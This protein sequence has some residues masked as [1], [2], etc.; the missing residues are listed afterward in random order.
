[1]K[2]TWGGG[3]LKGPQFLNLFIS[4]L[5]GRIV[6]FTPRPEL[7]ASS[8][9]G[10]ANQSKNWGGKW[11]PVRLLPPFNNLRRVQRWRISTE[12]A[13]ERRFC[14]GCY[15]GNLYHISRFIASKRSFSSQKKKQKKNT[16]TAARCSDDAKTYIICLTLIFKLVFLVPVIEANIYILMSSLYI[17]SFKHV[18]H[19]TTCCGLRYYRD[20]FG[21]LCI[22]VC[23]VGCVRFSGDE[24]IEYLRNFFF[25]F[26]F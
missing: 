22:S 4:F 6:P 14:V 2:D 13:T 23:P 12:L 9:A 1:M 11:L 8:S 7:A 20:R 25:F 18:L 3:A 21:L 5:A 17:V 24:D 10:N 16:L 26:F 19:I 15:K